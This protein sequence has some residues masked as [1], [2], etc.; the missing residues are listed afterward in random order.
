MFSV[1]RTGTQGSATHA[2]S[3]SSPATLT[4]D[5][6]DPVQPHHRTSGASIHLELSCKTT[7]TQADTD[8][9]DYPLRRDQPETVFPTV[10]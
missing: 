1:H 7:N 6:S 8:R 2:D 5:I 4:F 9:S 3:L 10:D